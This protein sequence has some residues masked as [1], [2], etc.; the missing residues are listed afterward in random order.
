MRGPE[1]HWETTVKTDVQIC[2][3]GAGVLCKTMV[4]VNVC[5]CSC[6]SMCTYMWV[7]IC[8]N[9]NCSMC[10]CVILAVGWQCHHNDPDSIPKGQPVCTVITPLSLSH[11][12]FSLS[13][14][15]SGG[16]L[17][18]W[19]SKGLSWRRLQSYGVQM[20]TVCV[21]FPIKALI[22]INPN[23]RTRSGDA[24]RANSLSAFSLLSLSLSDY[25]PSILPPGIKG[26]TR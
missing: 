7:G 22:Q 16:S 6:T 20:F 1:W 2:C 26:A 15:V 12:T 10:V 23:D 4:G 9:W 25:W 19:R 3:S 8:V 13:A 17:A 18:V 24:Q 5:M 21:C 11:G 14:C